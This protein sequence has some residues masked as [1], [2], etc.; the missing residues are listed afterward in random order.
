L[1]ETV[2]FQYTL[3][4]VGTE[5]ERRSAAIDSFYSSHGEEEKMLKT[6][7]GAMDAYLKFSIIGEKDYEAINKYYIDTKTPPQMAHFDMT[8]MFDERKNFNNSTGYYITDIYI[9]KMSVKSDRASVV[10]NAS[11]RNSSGSALGVGM[12]LELIKMDGLWYVTGLS[13]FP[14]SKKAKDLKVKVEK[15]IRDMKAGSLFE[16]DLKVRILK[17]AKYSSGNE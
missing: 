15:I 14:D 10:I 7:R 5:I 1:E 16:G 9:S 3:N 2:D 17:L 12:A 8:R 13:T 11:C 6:L 4:N